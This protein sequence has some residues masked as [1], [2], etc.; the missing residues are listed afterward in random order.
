[1]TTDTNGAG[2]LP[3]DDPGKV[4]D[5]K[6]SPLSEE[7]RVEAALNSGDITI[8][9]AALVKRLTRWA[10]EAEFMEKRIGELCRATREV[11]GETVYMLRDG[12]TGKLWFDEICVWNTEFD[13]A[14]IARDMNDTVDDAA[15]SVVALRT[16]SRVAVQ[17]G[18]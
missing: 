13:A 9:G 3:S 12:H 15:F 14:D 11:D 5:H 8:R 16:L 17:E 2:G 6:P 18:E 7:L 10:N 4:S 1:M